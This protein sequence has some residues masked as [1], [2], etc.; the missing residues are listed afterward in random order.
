MNAGR[1]L[2]PGQPGTKKLVER[3]GENLLCVR[4]RYDPEGKRRLKTVELIVEKTP[5]QPAV[6]KIPLNQIMRI[7]LPYDELELQKE[8]EIAG[9]KWNPQLRVWELPYRAVLE[10][11]LADYTVEE[12]ITAVDCF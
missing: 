12:G 6:D 10:L 5:W 3:Y 8:V 4:Y 11:E 7:W 2:F 9:G 1:K